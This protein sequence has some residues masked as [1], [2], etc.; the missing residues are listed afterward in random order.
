[1]TRPTVV[2]FDIDGTLVTC[3]GAGRASMERAFD[4]VLGRRDAGGFDFGGMTDRAIA[5]AAA[6]A[7]G[8]DDDDATLDVCS[9]AT[10]PSSP[11]SSRARRATPCSPA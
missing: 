11:R 2:L 1:M 3:G 9:T 5:R 8:K 4:E 10:S 7:A 6:R